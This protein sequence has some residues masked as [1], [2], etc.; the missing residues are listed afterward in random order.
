MPP[1]NQNSILDSVKTS[2][3]V[4]PDDPSFDLD[5]TLFINGAFGALQ[6]VGVGGDTGFWITDNTTL[7]SQYVADLLYLGMVK[8]YIVL[9]VKRAFDPPQNSF[10]N[11]AIEK[12]LLMLEWRINVAVE[13]LHPPT[14]PTVIDTLV[15]DVTQT[16]FVVKTIT[17]QFA[18]TIDMDAA[19]ANTFYLELTGDCTIHAPVSGADG[20]HITLELISNGHT[21]TWG[22]GWNFGSNGVP[23]LSPGGLTDVIS[24]VYR[25]SATDWYAGF[26]PGF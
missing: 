16:V 17:L 10:G 19:E 4:S 1:P 12:Q 8:Q 5:I 25:E 15:S 21:V 20:E 26:V 7:W 9:Y 18:S 23:N 14:D 3:G 13:S 22:N 2:V 24:A 6:Q 11:E